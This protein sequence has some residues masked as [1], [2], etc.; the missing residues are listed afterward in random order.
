MLAILLKILSILGLI[1]LV[2][3][4]F[5]L[6]A[7]LLVLFFPATYRIFGKRNAREMYAWVKVNWLFGLLR[8]R[9]AY[10][11]PGNMSARLLW[12]T[13]F[14]SDE[15][16]K[17]QEP[18][19]AERMPPNTDKT[20][21]KVKETNTGTESESEK[22]QQKESVS[23]SPEPDTAQTPPQ[24]EIVDNSVFAWIK[25]FILAKY[26]KIRYTFQSIYDKIKDI[27]ENVSYYKALLQ[28]EDT[29][30]LFAHANKRVRNVLK[31]IRPRKVKV[32]ILFGTG[33]P[34][35]TGYAYGIYCMLFPQ[36]GK[37]ILVTPDFT[38]AILEGELYAAGRITVFHLLRN[39]LLLL[40]DRR[41]KLFVNKLK[42]G[43][44]ENGR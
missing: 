25:H 8:I 35:T 7:A 32:D 6:L 27:W 40:L 22:I 1:L 38:Q 9:Y 43:R 12:F 37:D 24:E 14:D 31:S 16:R 28:E 44:N 34:D 5:L 11:E 26:E 41:L 36:P 42:A 19:A 39:G 23:N 20:P 13:I 29:K 30:L 17:A 10:P 2:L 33:S 15:T 18:A 4:C 21:V 3:L